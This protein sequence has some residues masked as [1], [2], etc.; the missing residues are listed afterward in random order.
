MTRE[1][2]V[3]KA[4]PVEAGKNGERSISRAEIE[5]RAYEIF[6]ERGSAHGHDLDDWLH[7]EQELNKA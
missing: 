1:K 3:T 7:A 6:L 5:S 4:G 2:K